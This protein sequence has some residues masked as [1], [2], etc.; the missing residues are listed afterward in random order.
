M[1]DQNLRKKTVAGLVWNTVENFAGIGI[2]FVVGVV[3]ARLLSPSEFGIIGLLSVFLAISEAF[4]TAGFG[5]A[6]IRKPDRTEAD[7]ATVFYFNIVVSVF[8][9]ALLFVSAPWIA[10]FYD[11]PILIPITRV[12]GLNLITGAFCVVPNALLSARIDF[13]T[14]AKVSLTAGILGGIVGIVLAYLGYGVWALVFQMV[15]NS[16]VRALLLMILAKWKPMGKFSRKSF[17]ELFS[18]GSKLLASGILNALYSNL[19]AIIIGKLFS[20]ATLGLYTRASAFSN[21]PSSNLTNVL[22]RVTFPVLSTI[23]NEDETLAT[24]YRKLLKM[25]A[26]VIFPIMMFLFGISDP[27]IR[28]LLT[29]KWEGCI[30]LLQLLCFGMMWYP[31][32]A[33][34]LNLLQVKGRSDLFLKLEI[35]KKVIGTIIVFVSAFWGVIGLCAGGILSSLISLVINTYYTGKMINIGFI[36][37]MIDVT[38]IFLTSVVGGCI[39]LGITFLPIPYHFVTLVICTLVY[40]VFYLAVSKLFH[41]NELKEVIRTIKRK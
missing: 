21:L 29:D 19:Y 39:V 35:F 3:L 11:H 40:A 10:D 33:I 28:F 15:V 18:Y 41:K 4:V 13:K 37:Q 2:Q 38:P 23:Q 26:Y 31:I 30:I 5:S 34:N 20:P 7:N 16:A 17:D 32:H 22:Q 12:I 1:A 24:I 27:F 25:S 14:S 8:F 9:Y 6:L 36:T